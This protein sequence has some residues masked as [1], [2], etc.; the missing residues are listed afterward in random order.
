M[1]NAF[2]NGPEGTEANGMIYTVE[3]LFHIYV[4]FQILL[5]DSLSSFQEWN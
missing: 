5:D 1:K 4:N 3:I 2:A